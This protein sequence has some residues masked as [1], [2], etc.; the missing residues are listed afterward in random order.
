MKQVVFKES[1]IALPKHIIAAHIEMALN[2]Y[3]G[4]IRRIADAR[5]IALQIRDG[6]EYEEGVT[7]EA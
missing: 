1:K 6:L 3:A 4:N 5:K 7:D 2:E